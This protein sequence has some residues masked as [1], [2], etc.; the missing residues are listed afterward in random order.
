MKS[1]LHSGVARFAA[2]LVF[3]LGLPAAGFA[4]ELKPPSGL[5]APAKPSV[6][7]AFELPTRSRST[8][9][10]YRRRSR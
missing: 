8:A 2:A 3:A 10:A 5:N 9:P 4:A 1:H 6:M 7:P